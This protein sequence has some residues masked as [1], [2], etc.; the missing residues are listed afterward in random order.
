VDNSFTDKV[1]E[2][3]DYLADFEWKVENE[4]V[5][6]LKGGCMN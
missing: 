2:D 6:N 1:M 5:S 3:V 4:Y